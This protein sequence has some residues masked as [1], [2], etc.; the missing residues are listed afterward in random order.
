MGP[1]KRAG[2]ALLSPGS[3]AVQVN[4]SGRLTPAHLLLLA[5]CET[6][7]PPS[8]PAC[9]PMRFPPA[10]DGW[11]K[12]HPDP[13]SSCLPQFLLLLC[14]HFPVVPLYPPAF[15]WNVGNSPANPS[16][17]A[18]G[19]QWPWVLSETSSSCCNHQKKHRTAALTP[20]LAFP[21]VSHP[22]SFLMLLALCD[23]V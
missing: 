16:S 4:S 10:R 13:P 19:G 7:L 5:R 9:C 22:G 15:S 23:V 21:R 6:L 11:G 12:P 8:S 20:Q 3:V 1:E 14:C 18:R 2:H 17:R